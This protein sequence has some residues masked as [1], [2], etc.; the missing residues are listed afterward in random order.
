MCVTV[1]VISC[2]LNDGVQLRSPVCAVDR[3][4]R[5]RKSGEG[6]RGR[7]AERVGGRV[8]ATRQGTILPAAAGKHTMPWMDFW[9]AVTSVL[10]RAVRGL[11]AVSLVEEQR[12]HRL[13]LARVPV[14]NLFSG[15]TPV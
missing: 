11:P 6:G 12:L 15:V 1:H 3:H 4:A 7:E 14:G 2:G 8:G 5:S 13:Y 9:P 10:H